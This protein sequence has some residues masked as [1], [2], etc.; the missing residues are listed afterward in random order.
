MAEPSNPDVFAWFLSVT[1]RVLALAE[2]RPDVGS[3]CRMRCRQNAAQGRTAG[4]VP[5]TDRLDPVRAPEVTAIDEDAANDG[6]AHLAEADFSASPSGSCADIPV[7]AI[8]WPESPPRPRFGKP[9]KP[10]GKPLKAKRLWAK[11]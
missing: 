3:R 1:E 4:Y 7:A 10:G 9:E 6:F 8:Y 2:V 11:H 5:A